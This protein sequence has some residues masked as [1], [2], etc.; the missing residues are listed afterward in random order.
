[1]SQ[2]HSGCRARPAGSGGRAR[3]SEGR[4]P[5]LSVGLADEF[6]RR[7]VG[8]GPG[9]EVGIV[10]G[11]L[12]PARVIGRRDDVARL[13]D[14]VDQLADRIVGVG[15]DLAVSVTDTEDSQAHP[16]TPCPCLQRFRCADKDSSDARRDHLTLQYQALSSGSKSRF[17]SF[18]ELGICVPVSVVAR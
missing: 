18:L 7:V 11:D 3:H 9:A 16:S 2:T 8:A 10:R 6:V 14:R 4:G 15:R 12:A 17:E 5:A 13:V 1:V